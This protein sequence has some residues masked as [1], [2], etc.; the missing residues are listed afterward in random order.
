MS[1][2]I[3]H[4]STTLNRGRRELLVWVAPK[5]VLNVTN[6]CSIG[7]QP[8]AH[9]RTDRKV[10]RLGLEDFW[11]VPAAP[12]TPSGSFAPSNSEECVENWSLLLLAHVQEFMEIG[13]GAWCTRNSRSWDSGT[14]NFWH[15]FRGTFVA[16]GHLLRPLV[17]DT[18]SNPPHSVATSFTVL[19]LT[20]PSASA[21][22]RERQSVRTKDLQKSKTLPRLQLFGAI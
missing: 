8:S 11:S 19:D 10:L 6:I 14:S 3:S 2:R 9:H 21:Q 15:T 20:D 12:R 17:C 4:Q 1:I 22:N 16:L 18:T 5:V 7:C 13:H